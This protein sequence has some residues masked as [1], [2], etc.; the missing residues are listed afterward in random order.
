MHFHRGAALGSRVAHCYPSSPFA[1]GGYRLKLLGEVASTE[2]LI[3]PAPFAGRRSLAGALNGAAGGL[4]RSIFAA[5]IGSPRP[6]TC[7]IKNLHAFAV[8]VLNFGAYWSLERK[9]V[10]PREGTDLLALAAALYG[11]SDGH[12]AFL[13]LEASLGVR[14]D[15]ETGTVIVRAIDAWRAAGGPGRRADS[16][17]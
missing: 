7:W 17:P 10:P 11:S 12:A 2:A 5:L 1:G 6:P 4:R 14:F 13:L 9:P 3:P 16:K 8:T 15:N